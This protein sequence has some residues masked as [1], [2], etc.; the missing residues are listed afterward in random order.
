MDF[1]LRLY[2]YLGSFLS[3]GKILFCNNCRY[4]GNNNCNCAKSQMYEITFGPEYHLFKLFKD[5]NVRISN[6]GYSAC[7]YRYQDIFTTLTVP[8]IMK[9]NKIE[10]TLVNY[11]AGPEVSRFV[12]NKGDK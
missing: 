6:S 5:N 1:C 3:D 10:A 9:N 4:Y 11:T 8:E 7:P 2:D 12:Y